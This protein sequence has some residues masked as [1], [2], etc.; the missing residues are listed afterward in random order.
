MQSIQDM[1]RTTT[2]TLCS[3][4]TEV[5]RRSNELESKFQKAH[6]AQTR[7]FNEFWYETEEKIKKVATTTVGYTREQEK[8][9]WFDEECVMVNEEKNC[10]KAWTIQIQNIT[11]ARELQNSLQ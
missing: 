10:D 8:R 4:K 3:Q 6:D 5:Q 9:E 1:T 7:S 11:R 2:E